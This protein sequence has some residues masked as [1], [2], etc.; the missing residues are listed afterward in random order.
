MSNG[1]PTQDS[2]LTSLGTAA[3]AA[4]LAYQAAQTANPGADTSQLYM[5]W[6]TASNIYSAAAAKSLTQDPAVASAQSDLDSLTKTITNELKTIQNV[7]SWI[8]LVGNLVQLA[9]T[10]AKFFV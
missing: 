5:Q 2:V 6:M 1:Q 9:T 10:V 4:F 3:H 7:S 8:T